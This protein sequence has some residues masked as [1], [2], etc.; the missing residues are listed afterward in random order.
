MTIQDVKKKKKKMLDWHPVWEHD[1]SVRYE[2]LQEDEGSSS[3]SSDCVFIP[4][5]VSVAR[6]QSVRLEGVRRVRIGSVWR[7]QEVE[8]CR[9]LQRCGAQLQ[10]IHFETFNRL[11]ERT[12]PELR[13][14]LCT[15]PQLQQLRMG[16]NNTTMHLPSQLLLQT[17]AKLPLRCWR[18]RTFDDTDEHAVLLAA[19]VRLLLPTLRWLELLCDNVHVLHQICLMIVRHAG[20]PLRTLRFPRLLFADDAAED[21]KLFCKALALSPFLE[22]ILLEVPNA[23]CLAVLTRYFDT[24]SWSPIR[25]LSISSYAE[26]AHDELVKF[27]E[28]LKRATRLSELTVLG[29]GLEQA[30]L[31]SGLLDFGWITNVAEWSK[32]TVESHAIQQAVKRNKHRFSE[33]K[34][35]CIV[36][37]SVRRKRLALMSVPADV[38]RLIVKAV[39]QTRNE[40]VWKDADN[41]PVE[42]LVRE[43]ADEK[44]KEVE[45]DAGVNRDAFVEFLRRNGIET[46]P[47]DEWA[48]ILDAEQEELEQ[49]AE[50]ENQ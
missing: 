8:V 19:T 28:S 14:A 30:L 38:V 13:S 43:V 46:M 23:D 48:A 44:D 47:E 18:I 7:E 41:I 31:K 35:F 45:E 9:A 27:F 6:L 10:S 2:E 36:F 16:L 12:P 4:A 3:V 32:Q 20:C 39:W 1:K 5:T 24:T 49:Q 34:R 21:F 50:D 33:C 37:L 25:K 22:D 40:S 17:I 26:I 29:Q 11:E 15:T 42:P